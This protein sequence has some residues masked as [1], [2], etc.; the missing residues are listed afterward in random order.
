MI[1]SEC[2][3][4]KTG[5]KLAVDDGGSDDSA[6]EILAVAKI[7]RFFDKKRGNWFG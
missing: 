2:I 1:D 4:L 3:G 5:F 6:F 7:R